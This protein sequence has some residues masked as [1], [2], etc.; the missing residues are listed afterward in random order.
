MRPYRSQQGFLYVA[1]SPTEVSLAGIPMG[2]RDPVG[3]TPAWFHIWTSQESLLGVPADPTGAST[4]GFP[5][6]PSLS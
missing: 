3:V 6:E 1:A 2:A 4:A 5:I